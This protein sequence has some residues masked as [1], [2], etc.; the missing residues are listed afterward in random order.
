MRVVLRKEKWGYFV[1]DEDGE[2]LDMQDGVHWWDDPAH[3]AKYCYTH[4]REKALQA[5]VV[6]RAIRKMGKLK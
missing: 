6:Q 3:V 1:M 4:N 2:Y 5:I